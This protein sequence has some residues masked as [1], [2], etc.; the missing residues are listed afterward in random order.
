MQCGT[1]PTVNTISIFLWLKTLP[2]TTIGSNVFHPP[3]SRSGPT[4]GVWLLYACCRRCDGL[5]AFLI[6]IYPK[7]V[8]ILIVYESYKNNEKHITHWLINFNLSN[9][10]TK[11]RKEYN[12]ATCLPKNTLLT[13]ASSWYW[14]CAQESLS[15]KEGGR[16]YFR[17]PCK[18]F[19]LNS[20]SLGNLI[21]N[22]KLYLPLSSLLGL[23]PRIELSPVLLGSSIEADHNT[24]LR[25]KNS[26]TSSAA[27]NVTQPVT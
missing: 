26:N 19:T 16:G 4:N 12:Q 15:E 20:I 27:A 22:G 14:I 11:A 21:V 17:G 3:G 25:S 23:T 7:D 2:R 18:P 13:I 6:G 1:V 10:Q 8:P 24:C 5:P 9:R